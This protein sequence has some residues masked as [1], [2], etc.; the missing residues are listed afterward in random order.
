MARSFGVRI[1]LISSRTQFSLG[2]TLSVL[3][4]DGGRISWRAEAGDGETTAKISRGL[5]P[6]YLWVKEIAASL[7]ETDESRGRLLDVRTSPAAHCASARRRH[8]SMAAADAELRSVPYKSPQAGTRL[9]R[10]NRSLKNSKRYPAM[11]NIRIQNLVVL[12]LSCAWREARELNVAH[13]GPSKTYFSSL[14]MVP[15]PKTR[16]CLEVLP[17]PG[18]KELVRFQRFKKFPK[19]TFRFVK[20]TNIVLGRIFR[21]AVVQQSQQLMF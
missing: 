12:I 4:R 13:R 2:D 10:P 15:V 1:D 3:M 14:L 19:R 7:T 18:L 11:S 8:S 9:S 5:L 20:M 16:F 21:A 17:I 6:H